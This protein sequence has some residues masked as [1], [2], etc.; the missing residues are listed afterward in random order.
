MKNKNHQAKTMQESNDDII[1]QFDQ[2]IE[3]I[4]D[5]ENNLTIQNSGDAITSLHSFWLGENCQV[6]AHTFRLG[7]TVFI[8][9]NR[10]VF[11][12]SALLPCAKEGQVAIEISHEISDFFEGLSE[13]WPPPKNIPI[14]RLEHGHELLAPKRGGFKRKTCAVC[15]HTFRLHD[16]VIIC[17]CSPNDPKC[18]TAIHRDPI[19]GLHCYEAWNPG[20]NKQEYCP[21]TQRKLN[22]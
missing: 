20:A 22:E 13:T 2:G 17:P 7:D 1:K 4:S 6:C 14:T 11:H 21:V 8:D 5:P 12:N 9:K 3:L 16:H 19:H 18:M 10:Q 15:G